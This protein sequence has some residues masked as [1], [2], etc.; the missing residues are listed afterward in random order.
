MF[1]QEYGILAASA[2]DRPFVPISSVIICSRNTSSN[3][4]EV[5]NIPEGMK[6]A[7]RKWDDGKGFGECG[8]LSLAAALEGT[9]VM[10]GSTSESVPT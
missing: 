6:L 3:V 2:E 4:K 1:A 7:F 8:V 9:G 10:R 5:V